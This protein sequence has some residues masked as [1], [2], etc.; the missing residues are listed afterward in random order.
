MLLNQ[1]VVLSGL[2]SLMIASEDG[3]PANEYRIQRGVVEFRAVKANGEPY[4]HPNGRWR[5]LGD[6]EIRLH[7]AL[8]TPVANWLNKNLYGSH[9]GDA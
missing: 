9:V 6:D 8:Q 3:A 1:M 4:H 5:V 2:N 7:F